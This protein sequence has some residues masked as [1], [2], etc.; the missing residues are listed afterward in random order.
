MC[1]A[2]SIAASHHFFGRNL[3]LDQSYGEAV[4]V[5]PR[6]VPLSF[7]NVHAMPSHYAMIGMAHVEEEVP[8]FYDAA[9]EHSLAMAGLLFPGNAVYHPVRKG[10]DNVASFELISYILG[11]CKSVREAVACLKT[12]NLTSLPF[13]DKLPPSPLHFLLSD[14]HEAVVIEPMADGLRI[15]PDI[16]RVLTNNPPFPFQLFQLNNYRNVGC[17]NGQNRFSDQLPL[18]LYCQGLGGIGLPGDNSSMSRFVR[19]VFL[20]QSLVMPQP[21]SE[22]GSV[23]QIFHALHGVEMVRGSC[24]TSCNSLDETV[25]TC[26]IDADTGRYYY[27][28]YENHQISCVDMTRL[29]LNDDKIFS[30]PMVQ[31]ERISF[32]N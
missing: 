21:E 8:L 29:D 11:Q 13:S 31:K 28:T 30:F 24:R 1:T 22:E 4:C 20:T 6:H 23:N 17:D 2:I 25:Y 26:C 16:V 3:D 19:A 18:S 14:P 15:Y 7:R 10:C 27:T 12:V 9:N 5:C 32:L